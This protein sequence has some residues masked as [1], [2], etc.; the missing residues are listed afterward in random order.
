MTDHDA[1]H[2]EPENESAASLPV[3]S[4]E[5]PA[6]AELSTDA[7]GDYGREDQETASV[8]TDGVPLGD[9]PA[10]PVQVEA[11]TGPSIDPA[12]EAEAGESAE[13]AEGFAADAA[14]TADAADAATVTAPLPIAMPTGVPIPGSEWGFIDGEGN[15]R[16][17]DTPRHPGRVVGLARGRNPHATF[18]FFVD[19][20]DRL[21]A[22][23][24][25]LEREIAGA[26]NKGRFSE[27]IDRMFERV[28]TA[29]ALGDFER[30]LERLE[31]LEVLV[32]GFQAEQKAKKE[33][34]CEQA[35]VLRESTE[36]SATTD[37][38]KALQDEWKTLGS[39]SREEDEALWARF[40]GA[41]DE[42]FRRRDEDRNRRKEERSEARKRK[43]E[44][45]ARAEEIALSEEWEATA[46]EHARLMDAWKS[47]GWSGRG[48]D[49][50][51]WERF[52]QARS[53]F[54]DRRREARLAQRQEGDEA[55]KRREALCDAAEALLESPDIFGAC[56]QAKQLQAEW[57]E[58]GRMPRALSEQLWQRFRAACDKVFERAGEERSRRRS[59]TRRTHEDSFSRHREQAE[60]LRESIVRDVDH[61]ERWRRALT[62]LGNGDQG[63]LLRRGLE[64]KIGGVEE[65]LAEKRER[66]RELEERIRQET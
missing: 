24:D 63:S 44:I 25:Q 9:E 2:D 11:E 22:F 51:L 65:R 18:A 23:V 55:R 13:P 14:D 43:E 28:R 39:A 58:A 27:R 66:L 40:R 26:D 10:A 60:S 20:F 54:F 31:A 32:L 1:K 16:Q 38:L 64:E 53:R 17:I 36:W 19:R 12:P 29:D 61:I 47:A 42:F 52:S 34:L 7:S 33:A 30:L 6:G 8:T 4:H 59:E 21:R 37:K 46:D 56:E 50:K 15:V 57:K 3:D 45:C 41:L 35:E 5:S 62:G 49:E 48:A